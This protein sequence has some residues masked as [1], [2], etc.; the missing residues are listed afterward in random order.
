M[1]P[2][3]PIKAPWSMSQSGLLLSNIWIDWF[4][5]IT[6]TLSLNSTT[7]SGSTIINQITQVV[8]TSEQVIAQINSRIDDLELYTNLN[9][10]DTETAT[11][12]QTTAES[13][14]NAELLVWMN[15]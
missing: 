4:Q 3:P 11:S 1:I 14:S 9:G 6:D 7:S 15:F 12:I 8:N 2:P 10:G 5:R 13:A